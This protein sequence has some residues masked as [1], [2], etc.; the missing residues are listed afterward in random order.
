MTHGSLF[1]G[2]GGFDLGFQWAGIETLWQ[3]EIDD[4]CRQV[5]ERH[6]PEVE[7][8]KDVRE[9]GKHN[10][11]PVDVISGG[12]P[13]QPWSIAGKQRGTEDDRNFWP[14]MFRIIRE[15]RPRWVVGE[16]VPHLD[17]M[18][19]LDKAIDDLESIGYEARPLEIPAAGVGADHLRRRIWIVA[20]SQCPRTD[21]QQENKTLLGNG[22]VEA[23]SNRLQTTPKIDARRNSAC[24]GGQ[25]D[26]PHPNNPQTTRQRKHGGKIHA[27]SEAGGLD[28][29][30]SKGWW[31]TEPDVGRTLDGFSAWLD[32]L[33]LRV[34]QELTLAYGKAENKS[35]PEALQPLWD[36]TEAEVLREQAG[37]QDCISPQE[38]LLTYLCK[39][40]KSNFDEA[41]LQLEGKKASKAGVRS[42]SPADK[43]TSPPHRSKHKKQ[44]LREHPNS[45]QALSRLLALDSQ[46]AWVAYRRSDA[47]PKVNWESGIPRVAYGVPSRVHRLKGLGN[48]VVPQIPYIIA[49]YILES[50]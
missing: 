15:L 14:E 47:C 18:G 35:T 13:C 36:T 38:V 49:K 43:S 37:G 30:S 7:R 22:R 21:G 33:D 4:Y 26:V 46:K 50:G 17:T 45:M 28:Q 8:F 1:S 27:R 9:V 42:L 29:P 39:L 25:K 20:Y 41:R 3:V 23:Q 34:S 31:S 10:L 44:Y 2:I 11:T 40:Q 24:R 19:Y 32:G 6:F 16:N 12:F 5:L 48:A